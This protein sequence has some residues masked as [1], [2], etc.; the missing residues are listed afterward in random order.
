DVAPAKDGSVWTGGMNAD[1][2]LRLNLETGKFTEYPL[3]SP[4][5]VRPVFV[6][7]N[8]TPPGVWVGHNHGAPP[9]K[10]ERLGESPNPSASWPG[11]SWLVP[12]IHVLLVASKTDVD[13]RHEATAVRLMYRSS[14]EQVVEKRLAGPFEFG[15][16]WSCLFC[17]SGWLGRVER[18]RGSHG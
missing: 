9:I 1:R 6:D 8:A 10:V 14:R 18:V 2:I 5:N 15:A 11:L 7:N 3:P 17:A 16:A 13:A 12:A 4:T